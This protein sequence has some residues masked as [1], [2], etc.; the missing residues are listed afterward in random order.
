MNIV[1]TLL[2]LLN[3]YIAEY[4]DEERKVPKEMDEILNSLSLFSLIWAVGGALDET[5][6]KILN[7][8]ILSLIQGNADLVTSYKL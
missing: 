1:K 3:T 4:E 8:V 6:R 5:S 2:N 7:E